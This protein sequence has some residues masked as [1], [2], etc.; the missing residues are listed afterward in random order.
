[1][2]GMADPCIENLIEFEGL[3]LK[4][5]GFSGS[6]WRER[7]STESITTLLCIIWLISG[8]FAGAGIYVGDIHWIGVYV[9][10]VIVGLV[11]TVS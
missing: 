5:V 6:R 10:T 3:N 4:G 9:L 2:R 8:Y 7:R 1:M 11:F